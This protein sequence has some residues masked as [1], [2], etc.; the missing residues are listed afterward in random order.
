M[1]YKEL[2][3]K[4]YDER[5]KKFGVNPKTL[6]WLKGRQAI[7]FSVLTSIGSMNHKKILD[8]GCGFGDLYEYLQQKNLE[9]NYFGFDF[10]PNLLNIA[11]EKYPRTKFRLFDLEKD[12]LIEKFDWIIVSGLFN[13]KRKGNY[14]FIESSLKKLFQNCKRGIAVDF[15]TSYVDF[16]NPESFYASPEKILKIAK[17]ISDRVTIRQDYMK[18]EFV[19]YI[20]KNSKANKKFVYK[21]FTKTLDPKFRSENW[22]KI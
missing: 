7:R 19:L 15:I 8:V 6:G 14:K 13:H 12:H 20:Y 11:K 10:N 5:L 9:F 1:D 2:T 4:R 17:N 16:R 22:L 21:E 18:F 3:K